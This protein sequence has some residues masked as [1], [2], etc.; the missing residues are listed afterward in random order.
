MPPQAG[1]SML[2]LDEN[3]LTVVRDGIEFAD[4]KGVSDTPLYHW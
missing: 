2:A 4:V 1:A 3:V